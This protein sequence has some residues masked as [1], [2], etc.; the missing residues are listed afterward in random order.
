MTSLMD[1]MA[2]WPAAVVYVIVGL[3][4][5]V[6]SLGIP[7][8]GETSVIA[9]VLLAEHPGSPETSLGI[10]G[11]SVVGAVIGD[12]LGYILGRRRGAALLRRLGKRWP[13]QFSPNRIGYAEHLYVRYGAWAVFF[14]R[15]VALLRMLSGPMSGSLRM[16]YWRFLLANVA[17]AV[18][19]AGAITLL[20]RWL[21]AAAATWIREF[22]WVMLAVVVVLVVV[23]IVLAMRSFNRRAD[24]FQAP[25]STGTDAR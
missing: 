12:T 25:D 4:V 20:V 14:G 9:G 18:A 2:A 6:E 22:G 1:A 17:G 16:P 5:G 21:G 11:A 19:W 23:G 8:P 15:F 7:L 3:L 13:K 24:A 10:F